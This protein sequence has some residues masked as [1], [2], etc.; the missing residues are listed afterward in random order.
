M[1]SPGF[2]LRDRDTGETGA[3]VFKKDYPGKNYNR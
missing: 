2:I 3:S 1:C